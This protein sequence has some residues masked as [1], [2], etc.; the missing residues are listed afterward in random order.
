MW[1]QLIRPKPASSKTFT[2]E[3]LK[4]ELQNP[5]N[6]KDV[7]ALIDGQRETSK[8]FIEQSSYAVL[9]RME[10]LR[11]N[12]DINNLSDQGVKFVFNH[13]KYTEIATAINFD[14]YINLTKDLFNNWVK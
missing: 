10:W 3:Y 7:I 13:E 14:K 6:E 12:R 11:R 8:R 2:A 1:Q 5:F 4:E 9:N